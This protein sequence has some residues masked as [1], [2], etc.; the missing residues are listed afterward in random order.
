MTLIKKKIQ[1]FLEKFQ[2]GPSHREFERTMRQIA[3]R[4]KKSQIARDLMLGHHLGEYK[5]QKE[6]LEMVS[7]ASF[8]GK[9]AAL[10]ELIFI[11]QK[12]RG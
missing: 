12:Y 2:R 6:E 8:D 9:K 3:I 1:A 7:A 10:T 11:H 4:D 5:L